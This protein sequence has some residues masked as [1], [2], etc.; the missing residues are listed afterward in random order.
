MIACFPTHGN[1]L[2]FPAHGN[3]RTVACFLS[4]GTGRMS[5]LQVVID[6]LRFVSSV[7][8]SFIKIHDYKLNQKNCF[9]N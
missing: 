7:L 6:L 8:I 2:C 1:G 4:F 5:L 3:V 9:T